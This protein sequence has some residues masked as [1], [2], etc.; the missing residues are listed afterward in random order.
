MNLLK[1]INLSFLGSVEILVF[2]NVLGGVGKAG[3]P[4]SVKTINQSVNTEVFV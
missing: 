4:W 2:H 3:A 1:D